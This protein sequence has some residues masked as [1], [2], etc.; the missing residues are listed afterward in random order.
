MNRRRLK[1]LKTCKRRK[2]PG[3]WCIALT[4]CGLVNAVQAVASPL[5]EQ[6]DKALDAYV[7]ALA[8]ATPGKHLV[9]TWQKLDSRLTLQPCVT[10]LEIAAFS[11]KHTGR[12]TVR[13][14][15]ASPTWSM[16]VPIAIKTFQQVVVCK[17]PVIRNQTIAASALALEEREIKP[18]LSNFFSDPTPVTGRVAKRQIAA[19]QVITANMLTAPEVVSKGQSIIIEATTGNFA[20]RT[21]G[22]ALTNGGMGDTI[23]VK[24]S[25]SGRVVEGVIISEGKIRVAL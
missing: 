17:E 18:P 4:I 15:C 22:T 23:R 10:P 21:T 20:I 1:N 12:M 3:N 24:N 5:Q 2:F 7:Q 14:S 9:G 25:K 8:P 6:F 19:G 13:A 11:G 16:L